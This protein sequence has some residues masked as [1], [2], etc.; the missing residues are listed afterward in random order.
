LR[1]IYGN[2]DAMAKISVRRISFASLLFIFSLPSAN[3]SITGESD[4]VA[5]SAG[6]AHTVVTQQEYPNDFGDAPASY[7][8]AD[9]VISDWI[10]MG[11]APDGEPSSQYSDEADGDDRNLFDDE[12]GVTFPEMKPG[13]S[14]TIAVRTVETSYFLTGYLSAWID[15]NGDGDFNDKDERIAENRRVPS[16]SA[17]LALSVSVPNDA[18]V[19][20]PTFARFRIGPRV[21]S[22]TGSASSGEVEDYMIKIA[23]IPPDPPKIG[24][25]TFPSC[26]E[27]YGSVVLEGLPS[28]GTWTLTR[29]PDGETVTGS[30]S[31]YTYTGLV[32]GTYTFTVSIEGGCVS[33]PSEPVVIEPGQTVPA[34]PVPGTITQPSCNV[35]TGMVV[36]TDLPPSG[37][38]T[39]TRYPEGTIY[40]GTGV[41]IT[42]TGLEAGTYTF[43][44]TNSDGCTSLPSA[45]VVIDP[46]PPTPTPP[47]PGTITQPTCEVPT[48]SVL[49]TGLP[50][51]GE[52]TLTRFPGTYTSTGTG[53]SF[54]VDG[55]SP[56][57]YNFTVTNSAG[58]TS[59]VSTAVVINPQP[60]PFPTLVIT[61]PAPVCSPGTA[62]LTLPAVTA[63]STPN[64]IYTYWTD[65]QATIPL[66][67]PTAAPEGT[68]YIRGT[69]S[70][71]CSSVSPV[72]VTALQPPTANAGP[73]Q[74]LTYMF[75][76]TLN[77]APPG[78]GETGIWTTEEGSG[79]FE[80]P[81]DPTT[82]VS[83]LSI[84]ENILKWSVSNSACSPV[85]DYLM[86][87]VR[88]LIIPTLITPDNNGKNDFFF[89]EGIEALGRTEL[90]IFDRRGMIVFETAD[91][92]NSWYGIDYN[93]KALPDDTYFYVLRSEN[94]LSLSGYIV[95]RR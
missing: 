42:V 10:Y 60:G 33:A 87:T 85:Y 78:A 4:L 28:S 18:I 51:A 11:S 38:W 52:W 80:N 63:G 43:T 15:W 69:I 65:A 6:A 62:D 72:I 29:L 84:G 90:T 66:A 44:V 81:N 21:S 14:V 56:G 27:P 5:C 54:T 74:V 76:T 3:G 79:L 88:D 93:G 55:L 19:S 71:G 64:L 7:G 50:A 8:S 41:T 16:G 92:D 58:C 31:A 46:Q 26:E 61:N 12:D 57:S 23:C 59:A 17:I 67:T 95:I 94:G 22:P 2:E 13:A 35:S 53:S 24:R 39:L 70:G 32:P 83:D 68:Y 49:L 34:A 20:R 48:G 9:H 89:L 75:N 1:I 91:Y 82:R 45:E 47:V 36:L 73:D 30:G 37:S 40:T 77:A 86:I 25:I